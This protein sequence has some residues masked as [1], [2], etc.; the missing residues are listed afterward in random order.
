MDAIEAI[1]TRRSV[2]RCDG[3][4]ERELV[5]KI[6]AAAV[7]A[8]NH[9]LTQPWR[10]V[11]LTGTARED[12]ARAWAAGLERQGVDASR[13]PEKVLRAPVIVCVLERPHLDNPKVVAID[14]HYAVGAAIQN[15]LLAAH[16][17][18][19]GAMHRTGAATTLPEVRA[20]LGAEP[21]EIVAGFVYVGR[22]PPGDDERPRTRRKDPA[23]I[24]EWRGW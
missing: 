12:L 3:E 14:E 16:A 17:L 13:I 19:L 1:M 23:E 9:H 11:V 24:T 8:P 2:P 21:D 4:V 7:R 5:E 20:Y 22:P 10:F 6:L 18:G 15:M